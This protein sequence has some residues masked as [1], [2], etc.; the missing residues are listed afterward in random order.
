MANFDPKKSGEERSLLEASWY[1][2][3]IH[4][5]VKEASHHGEIRC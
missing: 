4:M 1:Q 2:G 3:Y 5:N